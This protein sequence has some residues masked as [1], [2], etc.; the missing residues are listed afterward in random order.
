MYTHILIPTDGSALSEIAIRQGVA[1]ARSI[2]ARV[3]AITVSPTFHSFAIEPL[4][5]TD[6]PDE[7]RREC[8]A[9][10]ERFLAV[11]TEAARAAGV[12]AETIH[13]FNDQPYDAIIET[14]RARG[15]DLIFMASHGRRG[16][17]ALVLGS[18]TIK[19]LTHSKIPVLVC[20]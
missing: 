3:T 1:F 13:V 14:A 17:S 15:C 12:P 9:R 5:L 20:R 7:Y 10:A 2:H 19:V 4:I 11:F 16:V 8:D 6:T 18:E